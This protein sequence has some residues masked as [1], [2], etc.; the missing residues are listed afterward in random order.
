MRIEVTNNRGQLRLG[1]YAEALIGGDAGPSTP[2]VP[3]TAVQHVG[4]RTVVYLVNPKEAGTFIERE[5]HL[6]AT[7]GD[8]VSV[9]SGVEQGDVVVAHG[10][11]AVRAERERLGLRAT[12]P[13]TAAPAAPRL[14]RRE[15][16]QSMRRSRRLGS[17][18]LPRVSSPTA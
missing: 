18:W 5:V 11:F 10:S 9:R 8:R 3:R 15:Y 12:G 16:H 17:P 7:A 13:A 2:M 6:G 14:R 1:M 4:D